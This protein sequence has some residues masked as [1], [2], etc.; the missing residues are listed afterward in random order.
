MIVDWNIIAQIAGPIIAVFVTA[1]V[2][3]SLSE[4]PKLIAYY[5]HVASHAFNSVVE[6]EQVTHI[7]THAVVI[8][9]NGNKTATNV[10]ISHNVLPDFKIYPETEYQV[11][12]LPSGSKELVIPRIT[13]KR[14]YTISYL[15]F[16]PVMYNQISSFIDSDTGAAKKVNVR[17]QQILPKWLNLI[18][19]TSML[20]G[21]I[22]FVYVVYEVVQ[23]VF[24]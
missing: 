21:I 24:S 17:L 5:G 4:Q 10:R 22:A 6:G 18:I 20:L 19:G 11:N 23:R 7:N 3:R 14:E 12:E 1:I 13:P 15:Y 2:T 16:P 9:N 8:R